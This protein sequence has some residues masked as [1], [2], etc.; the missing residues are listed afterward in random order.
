[1]S[2]FAQPVPG[3]LRIRI[4]FLDADAGIWR[5]YDIAGQD[6]AAICAIGMDSDK[7]AL[8]PLSGIDHTLITT[9][10]WMSSAFQHPVPTAMTMLQAMVVNLTRLITQ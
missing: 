2:E 7:V 3:T 4:D 9:L 6:S 1:M 5:H 8:S 10:S